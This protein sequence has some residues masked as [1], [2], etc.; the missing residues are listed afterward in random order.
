MCEVSVCLYSYLNATFLGEGEKTLKDTIIEMRTPIK[1]S[2]LIYAQVSLDRIYMGEWEACLACMLPL[3][4]Q[5][6]H[7]DNRVQMR[8][9]APDTAIIMYQFKPSARC[10]IVL[11]PATQTVR[12]TTPSPIGSHPCVCRL[13]TLED[14][15]GDWIQQ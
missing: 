11:P 10:V 1:I 15:T 12:I 3:C 14:W 2:A 5:P 8:A 4:C 7:A 9:A 13:S 6:A